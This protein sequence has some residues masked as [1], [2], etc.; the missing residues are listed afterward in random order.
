MHGWTDG[1]LDG[2]TSACMCVHVC[3][4]GRRQYICTRLDRSF[5]SSIDKLY[6]FVFNIGATGIRRSCTVCYAMIAFGAIGVSSD[7]LYR[8]YMGVSE[9]RGPQYSTLNKRILIIRTPK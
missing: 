2:C 1:S 4:H 3:R 6:T 7:P 9:N 5:H 8:P